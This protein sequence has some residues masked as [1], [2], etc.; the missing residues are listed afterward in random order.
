MRPELDAIS[1]DFAVRLTRA[2]LDQMR[3][4]IQ[5]V[6]ERW[7]AKSRS[8]SPDDEGDRRGYYGVIMAAPEEDLFTAYNAQRNQR[9]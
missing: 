4:E 2:E 3:Q 1:G 6:L 9:P 7:S 8:A 5:A